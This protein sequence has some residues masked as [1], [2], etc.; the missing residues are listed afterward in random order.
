MIFFFILGVIG[1]ALTLLL[2]ET[3]NKPIRA[4]IEEIQFAK[5]KRKTQ[6]ISEIKSGIIESNKEL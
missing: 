5:N 4:D 6:Y 3:H 1:S 2:E